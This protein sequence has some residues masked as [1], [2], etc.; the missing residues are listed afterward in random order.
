MCLSVAPPD[1]ILLRTP[2]TTHMQ[3]ILMLGACIYAQHCAIKH[4]GLTWRQWRPVAW[5]ALRTAVNPRILW[6]YCRIALPGGLMNAFEG[7][8]FDITTAFAGACSAVPCSGRVAGLSSVPCSHK[9]CAALS[10]CRPLAYE[11]SLTFKN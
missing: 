1:P 8:A 7:G 10:L 2:D 5:A 4:A 6:A 3:F 11:L 9:C